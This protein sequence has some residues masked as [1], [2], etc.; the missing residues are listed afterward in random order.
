MENV[1]LMSDFLERPAANECQSRILTLRE[2]TSRT[3]LIIVPE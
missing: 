3:T 1:D 2:A